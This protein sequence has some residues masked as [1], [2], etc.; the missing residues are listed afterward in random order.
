MSKKFLL[1][2]FALWKYPRIRWKV[3]GDEVKGPLKRIKI[4]IFNFEEAR[5]FAFNFLIILKV[6]L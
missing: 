6:L 1:K 2:K 5:N 4:H 3:D